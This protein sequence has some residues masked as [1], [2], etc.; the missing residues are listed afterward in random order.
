M[1]VILVDIHSE[2]ELAAFVDTLRISFMPFARIEN[3]SRQGGRWNS[4]VGG[5]RVRSLTLVWC[6]GEV[7]V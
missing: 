1:R 4:M 7:E 5:V 6:D 3:R 2:V